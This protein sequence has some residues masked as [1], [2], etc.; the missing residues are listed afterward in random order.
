MIPTFPDFAPL[1][2][3]HKED[4]ERLVA[5][6]PPISD[7]S[8]ATLNIWW[9]LEGKLRLCQ[10]NGNLVINYHLPF[11]TENSGFCLVGKH[12]LEA[13]MLALFEYLRQEQLPVKLVHVPEFVIDKLKQRDWLTI[14]E[15]PDYNEYILDAHGLASLEDAAHGRTR[16]KV[17]RFMR[18]VEEREV[19][20]RKLDVSSEAVREEL[21][22]A[23]TQWEKDQPSANDPEHTEHQAIKQTL[24]HAEEFGIRHLG[25]YVDDKLRAIILYH[26]AKG[27]NHFILHHLKVDYSIPYIF[28]YMTHRIAD[29]AVREDVD[30]LNM[31]MDLGIENLRR[32][33]MGLRPVDF[34]RKYTVRPADHAD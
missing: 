10:L 5:E 26:K 19:D 13:S 24:K 7:I 34:F 17:K 6:Y 23:I 33:K 28:D 30:F 11:D 16:R 18:E 14:E 9:N 31:E 27:D 15:E 12:E 2:L 3:D 21:F 8:F 29:K 4:Y 20:L 25:L 32:H 1:T 22:E